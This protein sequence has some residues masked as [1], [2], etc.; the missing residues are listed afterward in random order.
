[1]FLATHRIPPDLGHRRQIPRV[2]AKSRVAP[3]W[4]DLGKRTHD[5][6]PLMG[7]RMGQLKA[8]LI[9][10][11]TA[12]GDQI[13]VERTGRVSLTSMPTEVYLKIQQ[14]R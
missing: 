12:I 9:P 10:N 5:E 8:D 1:M 13:E 6:S 4:C 11:L 3:I 2:K 14:S 7:S